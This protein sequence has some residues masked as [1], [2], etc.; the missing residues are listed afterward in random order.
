MSQTKAQRRKQQKKKSKQK[1]HR[2]QTNVRK[3]QPA[4]Q[5]RLDVLYEDKWRIGVRSFRRW[6]GVEAHRDQTEELRKKGDE[7]VAGRVVRLEDGE[8]VMEIAPSPKKIDEKGALPD[9]LADEP[10]AAKKGLMGIF[11]K[12]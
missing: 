3:N 11:R 8:V 9:K 5:W 4:P 7:I 1:Q 10:D 2:K 6:S 12:K